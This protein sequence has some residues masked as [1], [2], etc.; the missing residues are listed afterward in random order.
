LIDDGIERH[1]VEIDAAIDT[2]RYIG[3]RLPNL[4]IEQLRRPQ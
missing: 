3:T 4:R 1:A 2:Y